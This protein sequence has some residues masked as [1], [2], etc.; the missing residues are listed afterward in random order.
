M[1]LHLTGGDASVS[2]AHDRER[3]HDLDRILLRLVLRLCLRGLCPAISH[4]HRPP[5][6]LHAPDAKESMGDLHGR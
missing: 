5:A 2:Q 4:W 6:P 3:G 1:F